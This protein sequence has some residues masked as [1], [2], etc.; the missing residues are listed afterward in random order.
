MKDKCKIKSCDK[1]ICIKKHKLCQG[2]AAQLY[3]HGIV[4][5]KKLRPYRKGVVL[6]IK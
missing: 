5:N 3:R 4:A 6:I 1:P 2:H